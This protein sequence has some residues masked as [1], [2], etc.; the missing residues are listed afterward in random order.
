VDGRRRSLPFRRGSDY[1]VAAQRQDDRH[2]FPFGTYAAGAAGHGAGGAAGAL[3][4]PQHFTGLRGAH[5][6]GP[7]WR[8]GQLR[9]DFY[10]AAARRAPVGRRGGPPGHR[11][12]AVGHSDLGRLLQHYLAQRV[13]PAL[14]ARIHRRPEP[15]QRAA[16]AQ[17]NHAHAWLRAD[18]HRPVFRRA[19][20][21]RLREQA[22]PLPDRRRLQ[23]PG[24]HPHHQRRQD[25]LQDRRHGE[26]PARKYVLPH[27]L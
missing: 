3:Q 4:R 17:R 11:P 26:H 25:L 10:A 13:G 18:L 7:V 23:G 22:V 15:R 20:R 21:T 6:G 8:A 5:A 14:L 19:R 27:R 16:V 9:D 12:H 24:P 1:V 2:Q